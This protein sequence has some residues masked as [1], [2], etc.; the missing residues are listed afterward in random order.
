MKLD[1]HETD[2]DN[3]DGDDDD[4]FCCWCSYEDEDGYDCDQRMNAL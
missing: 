4:F 3:D 1:K 2:C